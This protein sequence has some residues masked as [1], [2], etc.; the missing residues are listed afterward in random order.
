MT[1][2]LVASCDRSGS[3]GIVV[4]SSSICVTSRCAWVRADA[5]AVASQNV[6]DPDLGLLG[7]D[8]LQRGQ[9]ASRVIEMLKTAGDFPQ[10]RQ[11]SVVDRNGGAAIHSGEKTL[12]THAAE[13]GER[14]AAAGN[15]LASGGVPAAMVEAFESGARLD[16][17]E[18]LLLALEAGEAAGGEAGEVRSAGLRVAGK[19]SWP[20]VDLRVD[21]HDNPIQ[22]LRNLWAIYAPQMADY[23]TRASNPAAAPAYGVPG[24]P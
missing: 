23:I 2:S 1:F 22:E 12:G 7:L 14:C 20:V 5:G 9:P 17:A 24:D 3:F 13:V 4:S 6:T 16:F 18:R 21:W 15:L 19:L 11:L 10:Y 8:L